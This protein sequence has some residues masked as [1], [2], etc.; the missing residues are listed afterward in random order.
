MPATR[1]PMAVIAMQVLQRNSAPIAFT[2][3]VCAR[4]CAEPCTACEEGKY[5]VGTGAI[6]CEACAPGKFSTTIGA[7]SSSKCNSCREDEWAAQGA[8]GC[9]SC[10]DNSQAPAESISVASCKCNAG[11]SGPNGATCKYA[12]PSPSSVCGS[13]LAHAHTLIDAFFFLASAIRASTRP[14]RATWNAHRA[15]RIPR[16]RSLVHPQ[17][18]ACA[19]RYC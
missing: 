13:P 12:P 11:Y 4:T 18:H 16:Q 8:T 9:T 15:R 17:I 7:T 19:C 5:K 14:L 2:L 6:Q 1:E 10:P 3:C